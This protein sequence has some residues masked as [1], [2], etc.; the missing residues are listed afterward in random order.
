MPET[1]P[2]NIKIEYTEYKTHP[3]ID[4]ANDIKDA[5]GARLMPD[6]YT[7]EYKKAGEYLSN[8]GLSWKKLKRNKPKILDIGAGQGGFVATGRKKGLDIV[9]LDNEPVE[10]GQPGMHPFEGVDLIIGDALKL[11]EYFPE[12]KFDLVLA[13][14]AI[15]YIVYPLKIE[16]K[17]GN[18]IKAEPDMKEDPDTVADNIKGRFR[19]LFSEVNQV[20]DEGGE[21]RFDGVGWM[22]DL[23]AFNE[24]S[25][26]LTLTRDEI[27][28]YAYNYLK[29][30]DPKAS[31]KWGYDPENKRVPY[32][33][34][35]K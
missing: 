18:I 19:R 32:F 8:F 30:I 2:K 6:R 24:R 12:K 23:Y 9:A 11:H 29:K 10:L 4:F 20:L 5:I 28:D 21:F 16:T 3:I 25:D 14:R 26:P 7:P 33:I 35:K 17:N 34:L 27:S 31:M 1:S 22:H 15:T 13:R